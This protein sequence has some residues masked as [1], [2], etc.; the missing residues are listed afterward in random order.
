MIMNMEDR[1]ILK[2]IFYSQK[3]RGRLETILKKNELALKVH[4]YSRPVEDIINEIIEF[5]D[6]EEG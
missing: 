1:A 3:F 4:D 5:L 2:S 6:K